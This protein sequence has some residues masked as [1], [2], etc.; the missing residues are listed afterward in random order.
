MSLSSRYCGLHTATFWVAVC[1]GIFT[2]AMAIHAAGGFRLD[3][4]LFDLWAI[5]PYAVFVLASRLAVSR[6]ASIAVLVCC[7]L[8]TVFAVSVYYDAFFGHI[9]STSGL[10]FLFIPLYQLIFAGVLLVI[11]AAKRLN[12][13]ESR[14]D[15]RS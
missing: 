12:A 2:V 3:A 11:V 1:G 6:G 10:V 5:A 4:V 7:T 14:V 15:H 13:R 9:S 8:A